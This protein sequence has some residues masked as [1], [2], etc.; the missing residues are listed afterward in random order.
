MSVITGLLADRAIL[1]TGA[2][3]GI[4][5]A[6]GE[7]ALAHGA[8]VV[9]A[10][11]DASA[12]LNAAEE[13]GG[14]TAGAYAMP[15]DVTAASEVDRARDDIAGRF[16][17]LDGLV[18]NAAI[19]DEG[20]ISDTDPDRF[21][22]VLSVNLT[23]ML[24]VTRAML[25]LLRAGD[26]ASIVNTLSTQAFFGQ[27]KTA[28]Y[29]AAKGGAASLTRSMAVDLAPYGIRANGVAPGFIDT[30]MAVTAEGAHEHADHAF[31]KFYL[32][33]RR[34]PLGRPGTPG[35]CAGAF[36]FLL[37]TQAAYITGHVLCVDGGL[38]ATY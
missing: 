25:P 29:A 17:R 33:G 4:G 12:C 9:L 24:R 11:I 18:N 36:V 23:S 35:D 16:G 14:E 31:R 3:R 7:R 27:P 6:V 32:E 15:F 5:Y 21:D 1:V 30:R 26:A 28:A 13:L 22:A 19:L 2:A 37:S 34:I 38:S 10:D 8:R 20:G